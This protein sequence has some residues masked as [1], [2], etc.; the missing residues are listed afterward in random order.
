M[1]LLQKSVFPGILLLYFFPAY[2]HDV[3]TVVTRDVESW[4]AVRLQLEVNDKVTIGIQPPLSLTRN[5]SLLA[6]FP[7]YLEL[8]F[9]PTKH[10]H[11]GMGL[12]YAYD[13]G[14][15]DLFDNDFRI[16]FDGTYKY[17]IDRL[18]MKHRLRF[19]SKN[20]I[21]LSAEEGD[22]AKNDLR[23]KL[24]LGYNIKGWKFDP[25]ISGEI[26]RDLT[27]YTGSFDRLRFKIG[28]DY[29]FGKFGDLALFYGIERELGVAY[30]K[31][32]SIIG[33]GYTFKIKNKKND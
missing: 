22:M 4:S 10:L 6:Q 23:Y 2:S 15:N 25:V 13:R 28:T 29:S 19:Q 18:T 24:S 5:A 32:T 30:P 3:F 7:P 26:W 12:R 33:V 9:K 14:N 27:K 31:T 21:G 1:H 8:K 11:F 16:Q 20:E 17:K